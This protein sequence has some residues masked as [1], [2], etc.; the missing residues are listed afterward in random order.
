MNNKVIMNWSG[1]KDASMVVYQLLQEKTYSIHHL[2]TSVSKEH[3]RISM[4]G[5]RVDLLKEQARNMELPLTIMELPE[6]P[7]MEEYEHMM[8]K[9]MRE[10]K[11]E[12]VHLSAF[13]DI[14]L[15][16]LRDYREKKLKE[17]GFKG[18]F[19]LWKRSTLELAE[20]FI[21][22]GFKSVITC[23]NSA[24][25]PKEFAGRQFD[26]SLLE[27]LPDSVDPCGENGEF[28]TFVYDGPIFKRPVSFKKGELVFR[29]YQSA[30]GEK[31]PDG[32]WFCD[33]EL[34]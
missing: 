13:G 32:F 9:T 31:E 12:N 20:E 1:G 30:K 23:V 11:E 2:L 18:V 27:D 3:Q 25:L 4:H 29:S 28:H 16:D 5:V 15:E 33:L 8:S 14:F 21:D 17:V 26:R 10:F 6:S 22:K 7:T 24:L 19:P 34:G